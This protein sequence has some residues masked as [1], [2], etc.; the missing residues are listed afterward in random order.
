MKRSRTGVRLTDGIDCIDVVRV[1]MLAVCVLLT[2]GGEVVAFNRTSVATADVHV[3]GVAATDISVVGTDAVACGVA[4]GG[5][6][7]AATGVFNVTAFVCGLRLHKS[8]AFCLL[9]EFLQPSVSDST[10]VDDRKPFLKDYVAKLNC[11]RLWF[12]FL[13]HKRFLNVSNSCKLIHEVLSHFVEFDGPVAKTKTS[14]RCSS[15]KRS[16]IKYWIYRY[17]PSTPKFCTVLF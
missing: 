15:N 5:D 7:A 17:L 6:G 1:P 13:G 14:L 3:A 11:E 4:V 16:S 2:A 8:F 10:I 12:S 9:L